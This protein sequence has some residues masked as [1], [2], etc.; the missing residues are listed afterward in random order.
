MTGPRVHT[1]DWEQRWSNEARRKQL[2]SLHGIVSKFSGT[3]GMICMH[4]GIPPADSFPFTFFIGGMCDLG[5][6][7]NG[8]H[9]PYGAETL[10]VTDPDLVTAAQQ[11]NMHAQGHPPLVNWAK[12]MVTS[13]HDPATFAATNGSQAPIGM[14]IVI[15]QGS[16]AALEALFRMLLEPGDPVLLEEYT[17]AHVVEAHLL[18]MG[19]ELLPVRLD[20]GGVDPTH[21]DA[22]LTARQAAGQ[23]LPR[24]LYTIPTGQNPTGS[25]M[26]HER[27][28]EV[29]NVTRKWDLL[30]IED[31]AYYWL[32]YPSGID[33][34]P[35][36]NLRPGFLRLD[37]DGRVVRVDSLAKLLGPGFRLGWLAGPPA[38]AA[39]FSL[40]TAGTSV[41]A[42]MLSQ[43]MITELLK[44]WGRSGFE[45]YVKRLQ[46]RYARNAAVAAAAAAQHLTGLVE[47]QLAKAGMFLWMKMTG[48]E[49]DSSQL[50]EAAAAENVMVIPGHLVSV[51]HLQA[52]FHQK[53]RLYRQQRRQQQHS[54]RAAEHYHQHHQQQQQPD[55]D[56]LGHELSDAV[57]DDSWQQAVHGLDTSVARAEVAPSP[58]FRVSFVTVGPEAVQEGFARLR[59]AVVSCSGGEISETPI[60][61]SLGK[62]GSGLVIGEGPMST[63]DGI[64]TSLEEPTTPQAHADAGIQVQVSS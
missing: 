40:Y 60:D 61:A 7:A 50:V 16:S 34:V 24:V 12:E 8:P 4:G 36:L 59:R 55:H 10:A 39:K 31:D 52:A 48:P 19:C 63:C 62:H 17:Y 28:Q 32:Q 29:Y 47:W 43:V 6:D 1:V 41:G 20:A 2:P 58:Y 9:A 51:A 44:R 45:L 14:E 30:I 11:Y 54:R 64:L 22:L 37:A 42:N 53:Q 23:P 38:L 35:G 26:S 46:A 25:V 3:Q 21:L 15:T 49:A 5:G 33:D 18:P 57:A 27:M 13:L 56:Q